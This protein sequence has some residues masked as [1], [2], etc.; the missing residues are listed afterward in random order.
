MFKRCDSDNQSPRRWPFSRKP[1]EAKEFFPLADVSYIVVR[2]SEP[3]GGKR[4]S[5]PKY[6][7]G[8]QSIL[9]TPSLSALFREYAPVP[10]SPNVATTT[11]EAVRS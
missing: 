4:F 6:N 5:D 9:K 7:D 10:G 8:V 1:I 11:P 2:V 3:L